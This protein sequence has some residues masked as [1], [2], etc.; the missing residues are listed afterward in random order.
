MTTPRDL[1]LQLQLLAAF[2]IDAGYRPEGEEQYKLNIANFFARYRA[3]PGSALSNALGGILSDNDPR[4]TLGKPDDYLGLSFAKLREDIGARLANGA[5]EL[6]LV[7]DF[8]EEQAIALVARTFG[9]LPPR[10]SEFGDH[11]AARQR[12]FTEKAGEALVRHTGDPTQAIVRLTW[13]TRDD[14]DP[15]EALKLELLERV[16]RISL[17]E[18]LR[19]RLGK[20]YSPGASSAL[21]RVYPGYGTFSISASVNVADLP[22]SRTAIA[23]IVAELRA[24]KIGDDL[25]QRARAPLVELYENALKTNSGWLG[26]ADRAQSHPERLERFSKARERLAAIT[27]ADLKAIA[28]R[29]LRPDREVAILVLPEAGAASPVVS[30]P[31]EASPPAAE[32]AATSP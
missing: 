10:D 18:G 21:S 11:A 30:V 6:A 23:A 19:E 12:R 13:P 2:L 27:V 17:T 3:T 24:G 25:L 29:Y 32:P 16:A 4:F 20:S 1:E 26:L 5:I 9:A 15:V 22:E 8:D 7:G 14:S 31:A 28:S